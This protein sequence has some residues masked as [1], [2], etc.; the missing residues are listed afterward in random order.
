MWNITRQRSLQTINRCEW[1]SPT[2][3]V[4]GPL[5][6][7]SCQWVIEAFRCEFFFLLFLPQPCVFLC[8]QVFSPQKIHCRGSG[9]KIKITRAS[10]SAD[11]C[12]YL[13]M[14]H[15]RTIW[16][17]KGMPRWISFRFTYEYLNDRLLSFKR[18]LLFQGGKKIQ[19]IFSTTISQSRHA[20]LS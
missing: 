3:P 13:C 20:K 5:S 2:A 6:D 12:C 16:L 7:V 4:W 8:H 10:Y 15:F 11:F 1:S 17:R 18:Q 9:S 14:G 19:Y